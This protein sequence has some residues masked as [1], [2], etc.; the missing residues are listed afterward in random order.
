MNDEI[1]LHEGELNIM[2]LLWLN[3]EISAKSIANVIKEYIGWKT[4][5]TYTVINR[6]IDKGAIERKEP[7]FLCS[8]RITKEEFQ[9]TETKAFLD[10]VFAGS[11]AHFFSDYLYKKK[12]N[13]NE[14]IELE[15]VLEKQKG[16]M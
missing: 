10:K 16:F 6:L 14:I 8:A 1:R 12:L 2:E 9:E 5:T 7:G 15:K 3:D 13:A 11:L 4:N